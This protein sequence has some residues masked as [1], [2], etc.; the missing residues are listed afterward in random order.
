MGAETKFDKIIDG[1]N[2]SSL[3][4]DEWTHEAHLA[5]AIYYIS[6]YLPENI[7]PV[8][9]KKIKKLNDFHGTPNSKD[10]GYHETL[11]EFWLHNAYLFMLRN[12]DLE[13]EELTTQFVNSKYGERAYPLEFYSKEKLMSNQARLEFV[14]PDKKEMRLEHMDSV[15][16]HGHL[17]DDSFIHL[18]ESRAL[19]PGLFTHEAHLRLAWI[20]IDRNGL[21]RA[22]ELVSS[23]IKKY[24]EH[25]GADDKYHHTLTIAAVKTVYHFYQKY[26]GLN[27]FDFID[28]FPRIKEKFKSLI[29][30]HYSSSILTSSNAK[31]IFVQ[32]DLLEYT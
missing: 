23:G 28:E 10:S 29:D 7:L 17:S 13:R 12:S 31:R 26:N 8:V 18:F 25:L 1:F 14:L 2:S 3:A 15:D 9:R 16:F 24:V 27:F 32:P 4:K 20:Y 6:R 21:E 5:M 11:T 22:E 19:N 30:A